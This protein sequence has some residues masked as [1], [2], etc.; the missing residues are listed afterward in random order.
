MAGGNHSGE[1]A[2]RHGLKP[3]CGERRQVRGGRTTTL[4][5]R[6]QPRPLRLL[7]IGELAGAPRQDPASSRE[8]R[9]PVP[10]RA[11]RGGMRCGQ[12]W[13][14]FLRLHRLSIG[15]RARKG[16]GPAAARSGLD[17]SPSAPCPSV[18]GPRRQRARRAPIAAVAVDWSLL[19][20]ELLVVV[21]GQLEVIDLVRSG[22]ACSSWHAA[23]SAFHRLRL[24]SPKQPP[25]HSTPP[26]T[27]TPTSQWSAPLA[28][29][30]PSVLP[31][32]DRPPFVLPSRA[33]RSA[34][35]PSSARRTGGLSPQTRIPTS[36]S[37]IP[38]PVPRSRSRPSLA[39]TTSKA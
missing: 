14:R 10:R 22:A 38:S 19:P 30:P 23:F 2:W 34:A 15:K 26:A 11:R 32:P 12:M 5:G 36:T 39:S 29:R 21:M 35:G 8:S 18:G 28:D 13:P 27:R 31:V 3:R 20:E 17:G 25:V 7:P 6:I 1:S 9:P 33:F 16:R 24:P 4:D 37:S